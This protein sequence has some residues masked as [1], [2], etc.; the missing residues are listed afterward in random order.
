MDDTNTR[1]AYMQNVYGSYWLTARERIYGLM[2]MY[3]KNL[4]SIIESKIKEYATIGSINILEVAIGTGIPF[5]HY[6]NKQN[7]IVKG[8]DISPTLVKKCKENI[9][10]IEVMLGDAENLP[11]EKKTFDVVYCFHSSWYFPNIEKAI[12]EMKRVTKKDGLIFFDIQNILNPTINSYYQKKLKK[13]SN[14]F[15]PV[16]HIIRKIALFLLKRKKESWRYVIYEVPT[17]PNLINKC[18]ND[19]QFNIYGR[20]DEESLGEITNILDLPL[21]KRLIY[22]Y[23]NN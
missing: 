8:V 21:Y 12:S 20:K 22:Y 4:I 6:F 14:S 23:K 7:Y 1:K 11:Y 2:S 15:Y 16:I 13:A 9:P 17:E 10:D 3:D 19:G 18:L 5:A